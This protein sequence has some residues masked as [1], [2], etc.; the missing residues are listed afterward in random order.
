[1]KPA[2]SQAPILV[3]AQ[4][5]KRANAKA[6]PVAKV[7]LSLEAETLGPLFADSQDRSFDPARTKSKLFYSG[8]GLLPDEVLPATRVLAMIRKAGGEVW[9]DQ[10]GCAKSNGVHGDLLE[11]LRRSSYLVA[12]VLCDQVDSRRWAASGKDPNW[13]KFPEYRWTPDHKLRPPDEWVFRQ[14]LRERCTRDRRCSSAIKFLYWDFC[15]Q[16]GQDVLPRQFLEYLAAAGFPEYDGF[17]DGVML[18]TDV[19]SWE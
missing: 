11:K 19:T 14:W 4:L 3:V 6:K 9:L 17:V 2:A 5:L 1:M 8:S 10:S 16:N 15:E 12:A 13:W 7:D 18:G